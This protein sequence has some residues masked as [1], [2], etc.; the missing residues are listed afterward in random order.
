M[1]YS[2]KAKMARAMVQQEDPEELMA[3]VD[4]VLPALVD[5]LSKEERKT[6]VKRLFDRHLETLA[7]DLDRDE[8]AAL[9]RD[10][11]PAIAREF[12]LDEFGLSP[13]EGRGSQS[14]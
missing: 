9:I 7:R 5:V 2:W 4:A 3:L 11:L 14:S 10:V 1:S 13:T 12:P 8:R 6:L